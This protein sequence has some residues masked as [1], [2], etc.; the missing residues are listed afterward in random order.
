M[1]ARSS[2]PLWTQ[3]AVKRNGGHRNVWCVQ[4]IRQEESALGGQ[5]PCQ[6]TEE[7][8]MMEEFPNQYPEYR[9]TTKA[10]IIGQGHHPALSKQTTPTLPV[11]GRRS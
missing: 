8:L 1:K 6:R 2:A 5:A 11:S 10:L 9:K 3:P 4:L 7:R